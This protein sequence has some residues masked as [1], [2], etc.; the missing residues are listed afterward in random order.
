M[1]FLFRI[2]SAANDAS[3]VHQP[4]TYL[5]VAA[6]CLVIAL[7]Y[8]RRALS[9]IGALVQAVTAAVIVTSAAVLAFAML[10]VAAYA[11]TTH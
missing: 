1:S 3:W 6:V 5:V 7:R 2:L 11:T 10:L 9:P 8:L 4:V